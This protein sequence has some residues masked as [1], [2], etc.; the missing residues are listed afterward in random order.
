MYVH[1]KI[2]IFIL[3]AAF[4]N[5][6]IFSYPDEDYSHNDLNDDNN[7]YPGPHQYGSGGFNNGNDYNSYDY[8]NRPSGYQNE[9]DEPEDS[10][11][12]KEEKRFFYMC[13]MIIGGIYQDLVMVAATHFVGHNEYGRRQETLEVK[14]LSKVSS[15]LIKLAVEIARYGKNLFFSQS[16]IAKQKK[17]A[18]SCGALCVL[19]CLMNYLSQKQKTLQMDE[20][21]YQ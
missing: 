10:Y 12:G 5:L 3:L 8:N 1:K 19:Y 2:N 18:L 9:S 6:Q 13:G 4:F 7:Y 14:L 21:V 20:M 16:A 15:G 17:F 11:V